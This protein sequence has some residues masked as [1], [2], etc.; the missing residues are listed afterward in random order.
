MLYRIESITEN[1]F[2]GLITLFKEFALFEKLPERMTNTVSQMQEEKAYFNG[3]TI[4]GEEDQIMGYV[5]CFFAYYTWTGKALYMDDLYVRQEYRGKGL[6]T[7]LI[8]KIISFAK[9]NKCKSL[10][11]QVSD[12]N[13]PAIKF[14]ESLGATI[15]GVEK[16]CILQFK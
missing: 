10:R 12:W 11:W 15:D 3:F 6:G 13:E 7:L 2:E 16:N 8:Q 5:T 9:E 4:K 1:D 14:Y